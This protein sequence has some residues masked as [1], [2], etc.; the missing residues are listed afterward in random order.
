[1]T[2]GKPPSW[3]TPGW[4]FPRGGAHLDNQRLSAGIRQ[5]W[6]EVAAKRSKHGTYLR[7]L[8]RIY[9]TSEEE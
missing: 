4:R 6:P 8:R 5:E 3:C 7:G 9:R 2:N 1:M